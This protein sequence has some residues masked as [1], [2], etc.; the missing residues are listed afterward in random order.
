MSIEWLSATNLRFCDGARRIR[1][2]EKTLDWIESILP[3]VGVT[4]LADITQLD[5]LGI[6]CFSS[7]RP[8]GLTL[9]TSNGKGRSK[10]ASKVSAAMEAIELFHVENSDAYKFLW[11][12][13]EELKGAMDIV[14]HQQMPSFVSSL[15]YSERNPSKWFEGVSVSTGRPCFTPASSIFFDQDPAFHAPTTNGLASGNH[16]LEAALHALYELIERD[17][18]SRISVRGKLKISEQTL[19][20]D[21]HSI[22]D[23]FFDGIFGEITAHT[24][25]LVFFVKSPID[26]YTFWV[27]L[28][29]TGADGPLTSFATGWGT[30]MDKN[31]AL[32][33]AVTE[34]AQSRVGIIQGSREDIM[35]PAAASGINVRDTQI[36]KYFD[37][38]KASVNWGQLPSF[39]WARPDD[40]AIEWKELQQRLVKSGFFELFVFDL[41]RGD[42][43]VPVVKVMVPGLMF[44]QK[45]F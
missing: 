26:I 20:I 41:T 38:L 14:P 10:V 45:M 33:R 15:F 35:T 13:E 7:I 39:A 17:A 19:L 29:G 8:T 24:K 6:P 31:L 9:Q 36:Y 12:S 4:R 3:L 32:S 30:H 34:A 25:P 2:P 16:C 5:K 23:P 22:E 27:V 28:L 21:P 37:S 11:A 44:N 42:I 18:G 43:G 40:L 1:E